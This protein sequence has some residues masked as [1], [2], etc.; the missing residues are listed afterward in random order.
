M[1]DTVEDIK[2][3]VPQNVE[4]IEMNHNLELVMI[5]YYLL[6]KLCFLK[7]ISKELLMLL[8]LSNFKLF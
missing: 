4:R 8:H 1:P 5:G 3:L 7:M 6:F 2:T